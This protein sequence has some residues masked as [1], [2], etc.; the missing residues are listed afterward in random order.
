M[1]GDSSH[2]VKLPSDFWVTLSPFLDLVAVTH[3]YFC[4][5]RHLN[6]LLSRTGI[7][8]AVIRWPNVVS[9]LTW[10]KPVCMFENLRYFVFDA[11]KVSGTACYYP[12][13]S[14]L[15]M[16]SPNLRSLVLRADGAEQSFW[17]RESFGPEDSEY[18]QIVDVPLD[19]EPLD[20]GETFPQLEHLEVA[21]FGWS[22]RSLGSEV[23]R[24]L[25]PTL[26]HFELTFAE[27]FDCEDFAVF[28][29]GLTFLRLAE[30][31]IEPKYFKLL[32]RHLTSLS[33]SKLPSHAFTT[34][35]STEAFADLP[36]EVKK[37]AIGGWDASSTPQLVLQLLPATIESL[38]FHHSTIS[39]DWL[40]PIAQRF[41]R[42]K[43]LTFDSRSKLSPKHSDW[44]LLQ[45]LDK[46]C[47][48]AEKVKLHMWDSEQKTF[49]PH[50]SPQ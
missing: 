30:F 46:L 10:P 4:G 44:A 27:R 18:G 7:T 42:L 40:R 36:N 43:E 29:R 17:A 32:P 15:K 37:L 8:C 49:V 50:G 48:K 45:Q 24:T 38:T 1:S 33:L 11:G 26:T 20:V 13:K 16:L 47:L 2:L 22:M 21:Q 31:S 14:D 28:P 34:Y 3:L 25:P 6:A 5:C 9:R 19:A 35:A 41:A 12:S 23:L 39:E